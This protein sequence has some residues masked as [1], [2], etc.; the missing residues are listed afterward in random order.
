MDAWHVLVAGLAGLVVLEGMLV[1]GLMR[2]VGGL[3]LQVGP[4]RP[5]PTPGFG[6]EAGERVDPNVLGM[7]RPAIVVFASPTCSLCP[8]VMKAIPVAEHH[9]REIDFIPAVVGAATDDK[10]AYAATLGSK[11]RTDLDGL[12]EDWNVSGTPFAVGVAE[13]G[14]VQSSGVVNNLPQLEAMAQGLLD[15]ANHSRA[16]LVVAGN[17]EEDR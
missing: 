2:Q 3:Y 16:E 6:P 1:V 9:Y 15:D 5:G 8:P 10:L 17:L 7:T 12:Y 13:D 4:P 14:S 11:A